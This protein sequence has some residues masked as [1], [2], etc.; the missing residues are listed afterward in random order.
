MLEFD[1]GT[2]IFFGEGSLEHLR[3]IKNKRVLIITDTFIFNSGI[4]KKV[5]EALPKCE[6]SYFKEITA[7]PEISVI[8]AGV[9][10]LLN[11]KAEII[12]AVGGGSALDAAKA[13]RYMAEKVYPNQVHIEE[14]IAI[15]TTSGTGSEVTEFAV[16]TDPEQK[17]K[18][19][20]REAGMRPTIA[21][22]E[23]TLVASVPSSVTADTGMDVLTHAIEAYVSLNANDFSDALAE[24]AVTLVM[25]FLP[26]AYLKGSDM[27]A[28]EKMHNASCMAGLAF[29]SAGLGL[30]HGIA[31]GLGAH[32][33]LPHGR[34][35]AIL[36]PHTIEY[37]ANVKDCRNGVFSVAARKYRRLAKLI[38]LPANTELIGTDQLRRAIIKLN[39]TL[40]IPPDLKAAN[41][42]LDRNSKEQIAESAL[43]DVTTQTNPRVPSKQDVF[44]IL[45]RCR[46]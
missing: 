3:S 24:K 33:H 28:R 13:I 12:V 31:H 46:G 16:I 10:C 43:K 15:P 29:A 18:F 6:I 5:E 11:A 27:L 41:C 35:N 20:L 7:E 38:G 2:K 40:R 39:Q 8:C 30:N 44:D 22:L 17:I 37:N 42:E 14:C 9:N 1:F 26:R 36:L 23:P 19:P 32:L 4:A 25:K 45:D 21:I 34:A